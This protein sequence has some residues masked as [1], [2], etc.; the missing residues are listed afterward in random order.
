[1]LHILIDAN[2]TPYL[3]KCED[4]KIAPYNAICLAILV[5]DTKQDNQQTQNMPAKMEVI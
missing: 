5:R 1:M 4:A 2:G 3:Y